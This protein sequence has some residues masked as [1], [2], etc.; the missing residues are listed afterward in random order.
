MKRF[1]LLTALMWAWLAVGAQSIPEVK[2]LF[3]DYATKD[4]NTT[5]T[6]I[7][8]KA[9]KGTGLTFYR[10]LII[11]DAPDKA[12]ALARRV[13]RLGSDAASREVKYINGQV[14]YAMYKLPSAGRG[15]EN[16]GNYLFFLN[17]HLKNGNRIILIFISGSDKDINIKELLE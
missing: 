8:G 15:D 9:L 16:E 1:L 6:I 11:N 2:R 7:S 13:A 14:Y 10:S 4:A 17:S 3:G 5:E 12:S